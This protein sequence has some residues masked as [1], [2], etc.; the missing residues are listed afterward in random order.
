MLIVQTFRNLDTVPLN[1][2]DYLDFKA[3]QHSFEDMA[4]STQNTFTLTGQGDPERINGLYVDSSFFS[5]LDRPF[6]AGGPFGHA[7]DKADSSSL[8]VISE[9]LWRG[10]FRSDPKIIRN[11]SPTRRQK[12]PSGRRDRGPRRRIGPGRSLRSG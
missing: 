10:R 6:V 7:T 12:L 5:V 3:S 4:V 8:V 9:H 11:E 1:Y 2:A